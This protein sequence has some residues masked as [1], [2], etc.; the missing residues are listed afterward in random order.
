MNWK[1]VIIVC[2]AL[3][4]V[5]PANS[6]VR[7]AKERSKTQTSEQAGAVLRQM[8]EEDR[9]RVM[10]NSVKKANLSN[11]TSSA[12]QSATEQDKARREGIRNYFNNNNRND[13]A[14][15]LTRTPIQDEKLEPVLITS[16]GDAMVLQ[17]RER[18]SNDNPVDEVYAIPD[19]S[20]IY[21]GAIIYANGDLANGRPTLVGL[22]PGTVTLT[23]DF[24]NGGETTKRGVI[25]DASHVKAAIEE[26][27][28]ECENRGTTPP[29]NASKKSTTYSSASKMA[30]DLNVSASF[31][32]S[33]AKVSLETT[34]S[35]TSL[36]EVQNYTEAYYTVYAQLE[37][38][39]DLYFGDDVTADQIAQK[40]NS[41]NAP[42]AIITSV[43]YG[44]R[45]YR[46]KEYKTKDFDF[47][48]SQSGE[49]AGVKAESAEEITESSK[50]SNEWMYIKGGGPSLAKEIFT[51]GNIDEAIGKCVGEQI[52]L[53]NQ[54]IMLTY[55]SAFLASGR[56]C[57]TN[58][59]VKYNETQY[60]KCPHSVSFEVNTDVTGV[61]G[62]CIKFK[63]M[64]D[65]IH[66]TGNM[67]DGYKYEIVRGKGKGEEAY[68][69]FRDLKTDYKSRKTFTLPLADVE[70]DSR[71]TRKDNCYVWPR[72]YYT[73]RCKSSAVHGDW[74]ETEQGYY[75]LSG[76][77]KVR[78]ELR[79]SHL[80]GG[81]GVYVHSSSSPKPLG[82]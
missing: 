53:K 12:N 18:S 33:S 67:Q 77:D 72:V 56:V 75:D 64:Y 48:S 38:D 65:V 27:I 71:I 81:R 70:K 29:M 54:G 8:S 78:V 57:T 21:P 14:A 73:I 61:A 1:H 47:K 36:V 6:Q 25:N 58:G 43:T 45:A 3:L 44:R 49:G 51:S 17:T 7:R 63:V 68:L 15:A 59:S 10:M 28:R 66:V 42:L 9:Q 19:Q 55:Q 13:N 76:I 5:L 82:H 46:F 74:H 23:I 41:E 22:H 32:K 80:K 30:L 4:M 52:G 31:L 16:T 79:G 20:R 35:E 37:S 50:Y 34:S 40:V 39:K 62:D 11:G 26:M 2:S 24:D 60:V 69:D